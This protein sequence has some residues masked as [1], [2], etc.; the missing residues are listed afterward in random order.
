M[1]WTPVKKQQGLRLEIERGES[2]VAYFNLKNTKITAIAA[3]VPDDLEYT[4]D[5]AEQ[6]GMDY[7]KK[8]IQS[9]GIESRYTTHRLG[10]TASDLCFAAAEKILSELDYDRN[11]VDA[12][13]YIAAYRDYVSP[14]TACILQERLKLSDECVCYDVPLE[15][16]AYVYGLYLAAMHINSGCRTVLLLTGAADSQLPDTYTFQELPMLLG[17]AGTATLLEYDESAEPMYGLLRSIGRGA[18]LIIAPYGGQRHPLKMMVEDLGLEKAVELHQKPYMEGMDV[19]RFSLTDVVRMVK[20]FKAHFQC[21]FEQYEIFACHQANKLIIN[22]LIRKI[23]FPSERVPLTI[24]EYANTSGA[25]IPL[26]ICHHYSGL[27]EKSSSGKCLACGFGIGLS[28]GI[29]STKVDPARCFPIIKVRER[30]D[31]GLTYEKYN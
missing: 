16:S 15:C 31:D 5:Y 8:F 21:D 4:A 12:L 11:K 20:D 22:S 6:F 13:I 14:S 10:V 29:V 24:T 19:M 28:L 17:H 25:S 30:Y 26:T 27:T 7:V 2:K 9:T 18:S 23:R 3:A 1:I